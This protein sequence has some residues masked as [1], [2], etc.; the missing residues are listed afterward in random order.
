VQWKTN[1]CN[2]AS[3]KQ[4]MHPQRTRK[5]FLTKNLPKTLPPNLHL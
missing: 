2:T 3:T 4:L 5:T 1:P